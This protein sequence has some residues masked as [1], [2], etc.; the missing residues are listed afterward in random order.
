MIQAIVNLTEQTLRYAPQD[1]PLQQTLKPWLDRALTQAQTTDTPRI[2]TYV[3]GTLGHWYEQQQQWQQAQVLTQ[4]ALDQANRL[5]A[6]EIL[7]PWQWQ[8]GRILS[9]QGQP[10]Q[11]LASYAQ[12]I[13]NLTEL[14][15]DLIAMQPDV[16]FSF[17]DQ[18]EPIYREYVQLLLADLPTQGSDPLT[19]LQA[20]HLTTARNTIELLQLAELQNYLREACNTATPK[21][22]D[23]IDPKAAVIYPIVLNQR[24]E[25][26]VS[27]PGQA[28]K[29]YGTEFDRQTATQLVNQL[30]ASL[31]PEIAPTS[32]LPAAQR[33]YDWLIRP[34]AADLK[35]QSSETLVFV[36]DDFLRQIPMSVLHDGQNYL[37]ENYNIVLTPG[38]QLFQTANSSP[39]LSQSGLLLAGL[40]E[41]RQGFPSLPA[42]VQEFT[43]INQIRPAQILLNQA[44]T[45]TNLAQS[46]SDRPPAIVHL[47]THGQFSSN[48]NRTFLLTWND[49]INLNQLKQWL[50]Q[51][52]LQQQLQ[53][54]ILSA[55]Q[56][57][58]GDDRASLGLAGMAI[59]SGATS[60][61][62]TL[63][64][65][66]DQA[67]A[68]IM[69]D[70]HR[71]LK[72]DPVNP[73]AALRKAQ[74][75]QLHNPE[76]QHPY[77]WAGIVIA[78]NWKFS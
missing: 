37:I 58:K 31:N 1:Q 57:A 13:Q 25:V 77:Y 74:L 10:A 16:Q 50:Q 19:P 68:N 46:L 44:F 53:L 5:N 41:S 35:A 47:A 43:Q 42:V 27:M 66:Q 34:I 11:A 36:L 60:T 59:R 33:F 17:R 30:R 20:E 39:S 73:A 8:Q 23:Q 76:N 63:W 22:I 14:R 71:Y 45:Q 7:T 28:L 70:L 24:L 38:L 61:I 49:R 67:T 56:T 48:P 52:T 64:A 2:T 26:I 12:A 3:L 40:S 21:S 62:A 55:C 69:T 51:N 6:P 29:H 78:G 75:N 4:A 9:R 54:L 15:Q 32:G 18:V 65:V 72:A